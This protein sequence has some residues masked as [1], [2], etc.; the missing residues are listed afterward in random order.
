MNLK[1]QSDWEQAIKA[2]QFEKKVMQDAKNLAAQIQEEEA[3]AEH[4][5]HIEK[6][7]LKR[8]VAEDERLG[9]LVNRH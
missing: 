7:M 6:N 8:T 4:L 2:K 5:R 9:L 3:K 1:C